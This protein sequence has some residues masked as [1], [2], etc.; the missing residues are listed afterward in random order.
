MRDEPVYHKRY[1]EW[2]LK[3]GED[4]CGLYL[5]SRKDKRE[6]EFLAE[7]RKGDAGLELVSV[8]CDGKERAPEELEEQV[9]L[10]F[11]LEG[12]T[13]ASIEDG[14]SVKEIDGG[15]IVTGNFEYVTNRSEDDIVS[16]LRAIARKALNRS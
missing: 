8:T 15:W 1:D 4:P 5:V 13:I 6:I 3:H 14:Y 12:L 7:I 9:A 16:D 11:N 10:F 2:V